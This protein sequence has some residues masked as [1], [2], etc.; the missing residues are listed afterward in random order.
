MLLKRTYKKLVVAAVFA[1]ALHFSYGAFTGKT[2]G[3]K[4]KYSLKNISQ[5]RKSFT[6]SSLK[7]PT[8]RFNGSQVILQQNNGTNLQVQSLVRLQ[9]GNTTYVYPYKYV[10]KVPKFKVPEKPQN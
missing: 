5:Y 3:D 2:D 4:D 8:F 7:T 9:K 10:V 1:F 6:L